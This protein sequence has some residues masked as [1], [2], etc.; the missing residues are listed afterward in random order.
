MST[1]Y[2]KTTAPTGTGD[3]YRPRVYISRQL[4]QKCLEMLLGRC[5]VSF[6]DS[7]DPAPRTELLVNVPEIDVIVC[8]PTDKIDREVLVAAGPSLKIV[9]TMS[10]DKEHIDLSECFRRQIRV[11]T[12]P[13]EPIVEA[14]TQIVMA[15]FRLC[16]VKW[17]DSSANNFNVNAFLQSSDIIAALTSDSKFCLELSNRTVGIFGLGKLGLSVGTVFRRIGVAE[18]LYNDVT[19]NEDDVTIG[20]TYVDRNELLMRCDV[21]LVCWHMKVNGKTMFVLNKESFKMMK[22][23]AILIDASKQFP[24]DYTDLC[25]A[26]RTNT[27]AAAG[28]DIREYDVIP[29]RHPLE[30]LTN[31]FFLPYRECFKWD[32]RRRLSVDLVRAILS[33]LQ[34]IEFDNKKKKPDVIS[35]LLATIP[36]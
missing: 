22:T 15:M 33:N 7:P 12:I 26:L 11:V 29:N 13:S 2:I 24:A 5:N 21:I 36:T 8:M 10:E 31:C 34:Q 27:I 4:P 25:E 20:A 17:I 30:V 16:A 1:E 6:W 3:F 9:A 14:L 35:N 23:S 28:L 19:R 18:L 32:G